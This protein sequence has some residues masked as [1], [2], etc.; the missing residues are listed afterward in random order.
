MTVAT[1]PLVISPATTSM[2]YGT[3]PTIVAQASGLIAPDTLASFPTPPTCSTT[4]TTIAAI[5]SQ[6]P[7]SCTGAVN[8][9]YS[10]TYRTGTISVVVA[11]PNIAAPSLSI[12]DG[13]TIPALNPIVSGLKNNDT[14][15]A[16]DVTA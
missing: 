15:P 16:L 8:P 2:S 9:N 4:A 1:A 5:G 11:P 13:S 10:I 14:L 6:F 3:V 7:T 12:T